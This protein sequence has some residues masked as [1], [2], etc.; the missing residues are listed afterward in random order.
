MK[1]PGKYQ[2]YHI[3]YDY[4]EG[5]Q[6][7]T[8]A[9][10][11]ASIAHAYAKCAKKHPGCRLLGGCRQSED[12]NGITRYEAP[13]QAQIESEPALRPVETRF[14]FFDECI[15]KRRSDMTGWKEQHGIAIVRSV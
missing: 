15:G 5:S 4:G 13:S 11:A 3:V 6:N 9:I 7:V 8:H 1:T 12:G 10:L 14:T 2:T